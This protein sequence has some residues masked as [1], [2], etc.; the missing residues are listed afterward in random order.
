[1]ISTRVGLQAAL[2]GDRTKAEHLAPDS[3]LAPSEGIWRPRGT[4]GGELGCYD[5]RPRKPP[6]RKISPMILGGAFPIHRPPIRWLVVEISL[7]YR[8]VPRPSTR[9]Q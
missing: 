8:G 9:G 1:M 4:E 3:C 5:R 6:S 7:R 2:N